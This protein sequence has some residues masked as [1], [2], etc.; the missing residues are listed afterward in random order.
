MKKDKIK[1][2]IFFGINKGNNNDPNKEDIFEK[3]VEIKENFEFN[4]YNLESTKGNLKEYFLTTFGKKY[5]LCECEI[6]ILYKNNN[7]YTPL[8]SKDKLI[9]SPISGKDDSKLSGLAID[10]IYIIKTKNECNCEL[11]D[12]KKYIYMPKFELIKK[13]KELKEENNKLE[14]N[15]KEQIS[16]IEQLEKENKKLKEG[17]NQTK[18]ELLNENSKLKDE[19]NQVKEKLDKENEEL[20][21]ENK[22]LRKTDELKYHLNPKFEDFYDIIIDI[23]SIK[24]VNKEG[25]KIK[26]NE[27]GLDKYKKFKKQ[28]LITIGVLGNNNKGKSFIL[29]KISKIKLLTGTSIHTEGLSV[30][31]PELKGYK[32]RQLI[33]LDSAGFETPVYKKINNEKDNNEKKPNNNQEEQNKEQTKEKEQK[34]EIDKDIEKNKEFKENARDKIMTEL[35]LE[36]LIIKVSDI[37][38]IVVGKLTYS[39]QLLINKVKVESK[40][41]HK[42]RIFIIHNL[43]EFRTKEQVENYITE[44][45]LKCSTFD[46]NKRTWISVKKDKETNIEN[47]KK[48]NEEKNIEEPK[49]DNKVNDNNQN[50]NNNNPQNIDD[51]IEE[52]NVIDESKLNNVHFTEILKYEDRKLEIYHLII[53]NED[54]EAGKIYN[55]YTYNFIENVYN[56]IPEPK[57]FDVFEEVKAN[58][59][60]L[61]DT[62]LNDNIEDVPFT[63]NDKIIE[64]KI[65]KLEYEKNLNLKKCYTDE[66]SFSFFKAGYFEPKYNYFKPDENTLEI[67]LEIPGNVKLDVNHKI[68]GDETVISIKGNKIKDSQPKEPNYNLF[69]KREFSEFELNIPLKVEDFKINKTKPNEGYPKFVN[70]VCIIQYELASKGEGGT[71]STEGL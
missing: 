29:S 65:I 5:Q 48:N 20:K 2:Q 60:K 63:K 21:N 43:Q 59:K 7:S 71:A 14:K 50:E 51:N 55:Q 39:E 6:S 10:N 22:K 9:Y 64:D 58:F 44:S 45:L 67:R 46:L 16:R 32:G 31:Y 18:E 37:L 12:F 1:Y 69:N 17:I 15:S 61:S 41:Q 13:F 33:L 49:E 62:I 23:N 35:F 70:G 30:K 34:M 38:L 66:L 24:N 8:S 54:S 26:F 36:N 3:D 11:K 28:E 27:K 25:W 19:F 53:A 57:Q 56:L 47:N 4:D 52:Q 42:G 68:V 40:K